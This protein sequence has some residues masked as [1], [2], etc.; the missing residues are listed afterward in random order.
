[1]VGVVTRSVKNGLILALGV[2]VGALSMN[3]AKD[4]QTA[5]SLGLASTGNLAA[6]TCIDEKKKQQNEELFFLS[7]GGIY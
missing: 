5:Q 1:M 7:C 6:N 2:A 4:S 3:L